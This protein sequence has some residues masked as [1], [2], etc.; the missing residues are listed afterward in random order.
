MWTYD[1][2]NYFPNCDEMV[3]NKL[4]FVEFY[5]ENFVNKFGSTKT[6]QAIFF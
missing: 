1:C 2:I 4:Y 5:I 6:L 3:S